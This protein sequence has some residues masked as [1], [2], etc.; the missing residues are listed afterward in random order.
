[1]AMQFLRLG[2]QVVQFVCIMHVMQT[3]V[4]DVTMCV[5][6]SMLPT[7]NSAGDIVLIDRITHRLRDVA[8]G[9]V[10]L[11]KAPS[12]PTQTVCKR[13]RGAPGDHV[14]YSRPRTGSVEFSWKREGITVPNGHVWLQ[15]D[16][17]ANSTDSRHYGPVP[18]ALVRGI[19]RCR[20]WPP[21][22][23][24]ALG[25]YS[26]QQ[27][28]V[29]WIEK[30]EE[31]AQLHRERMAEKRRARRAKGDVKRRRKE[32]RRMRRRMARE[33]EEEEEKKEAVEALLEG[34]LGHVQVAV[35][36]EEEGGAVVEKVKVYEQDLDQRRRGQ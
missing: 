21:P 11:A 4:F 34:D 29:A 32:E 13:V 6:P 22:A 7:I 30:E 24:G 19:V 14:C 26:W 12:D 3:Y 33:E 17:E 8:V 9:D 16:N 5:G 15:G 18:E 2:G 28:T 23:I 25:E 31:E 27:K 36:A 35:V 20:I 10:V 1:M